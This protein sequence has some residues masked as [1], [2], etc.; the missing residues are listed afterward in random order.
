[1]RITPASVVKTMNKVAGIKYET[2]SK[3]KSDLL[4]VPGLAVYLSRVVVQ[5]QLDLNNF[6]CSCSEALGCGS[7]VVTQLSPGVNWCGAI[8]YPTVSH[9]PGGYEL[10]YKLS[11][12]KIQ[13]ALPY[14]EDPV[15]CA[16]RG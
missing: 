3:A 4:A 16:G 9:G 1:M 10:V 6:M 14:R 2:S 12:E 11:E 15:Q 5:N 7:V 13:Q 8:V